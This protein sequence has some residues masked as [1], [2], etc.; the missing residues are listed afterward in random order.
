MEGLRGAIRE[1]LVETLGE[2]P[3]R[4][5]VIPFKGKPDPTATAL[6]DMGSAIHAIAYD[7]A[8]PDMA[9]IAAGELRTN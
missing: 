9:K 1:A 5:A 8:E 6:A 4:E 2:P 3:A 7:L